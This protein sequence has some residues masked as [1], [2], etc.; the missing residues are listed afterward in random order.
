MHNT[1]E[2]GNTNT[3]YRGIKVTQMHNTEEKGNINA[4]Y[5]GTR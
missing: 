1:E 2:Q 3:Q 5:R 4:Q